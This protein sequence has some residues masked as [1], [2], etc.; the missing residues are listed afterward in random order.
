MFCG[1]LTGVQYGGGGVHGG[2]SQPLVP[3]GRP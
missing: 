3:L 1:L 2:G